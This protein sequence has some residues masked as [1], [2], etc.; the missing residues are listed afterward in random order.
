MFTQSPSL[1]GTLQARHVPEHALVQQTPSTQLSPVAHSA[2]L[3]HAAPVM[4]REVQT[5]PA[6]QNA[7]GSQSPSL[8]HIV[9]H[10]GADCS[11]A[12]VHD[13]EGYVPHVS[14]TRPTQPESSGT[15]GPTAH[16]LL[17]VH[18]GSTRSPCQLVAL[19][20]AEGRPYTAA[21]QS[22]AMLQQSPPAQQ[23]PLLQ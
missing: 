1:P 11:T 9:A 20:H 2:V 19:V 23:K 10:A 22:L 7:V 21:E 13:T 12:L 16:C 15:A 4:P 18:T 14:A 5:P 17:A 8:V 6:L 3:P